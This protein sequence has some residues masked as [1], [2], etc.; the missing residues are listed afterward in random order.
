M[1]PTGR[2]I[3]QCQPETLELRGRATMCQSRAPSQ[4]VTSAISNL[5]E[6]AVKRHLESSV[7]PKILPKPCKNPLL[8]LLV[9]IS[10]KNKLLNSDNC[11]E[12]RNSRKQQLQHYAISETREGSGKWQ[13][14]FTMPGSSENKSSRDLTES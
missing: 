10:Q 2:A 5:E 8:H 1:H 6:C 7:T 13:R 12:S 3:H 14:N 4:T 11:W 9:P